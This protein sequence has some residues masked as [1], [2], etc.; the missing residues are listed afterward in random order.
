MDNR[1]SLSIIAALGLAG[2]AC[3][4]MGGST[5]DQDTSQTSTGSQSSGKSGSS[6][7][8]TASTS[9][10]GSGQSS[11]SGD[12]ASSGDS[13]SS[14]SSSDSMGSSSSSTTA[15]APEVPGSTGNAGARTNSESTVASGDSQETGTM[16]PGDT[17]GSGSASAGTMSGDTSS[18]SSQT[19]AATT[20]SSAA[21][22]MVGRQ[23]VST[24]GEPLGSVVQVVVDS[25]GAPAYVVISDGSQSTV[26][27]H[28]AA[29]SMVQNN[30]IV[31]DRARLDAAPKVQGDLQAQ[32]SD[33]WR[34]AAD[35]YWGQDAI[36]TAS[37]ETGSESTTR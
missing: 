13:A 27:P 7:S 19:K 12:Y 10:G 3:T 9:S 34:S 21:S 17:S 11:T 36:R 29:H 2:A 14:S 24:K 26:V 6:G 28:S 37:P 30:Q 15:N 5:S 23:V 18:S 35:S 1:L 25:T 33:T 4:S 8:E 16:Q 22:E 32:S 20:P 31:I